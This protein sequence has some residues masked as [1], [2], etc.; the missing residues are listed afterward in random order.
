MMGQEHLS[1][2]MQ[3]EHYMASTHFYLFIF[4]NDSSFICFFH[5]ITEM[6]NIFGSFFC[7]QSVKKIQVVD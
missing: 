5:K 2:V 7:R 1:T 4:F 6:L 3:R